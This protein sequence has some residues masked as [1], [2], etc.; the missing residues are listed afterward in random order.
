[1]QKTFKNEKQEILTAN[2]Y[3]N[4]VT[5]YISTIDPISRIRVKKEC[6]NID[7]Q[8]FIKLLEDRGFKEI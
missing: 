6:N 4:D 2:M 7:P 3:L 8:D 5:Y 1:M